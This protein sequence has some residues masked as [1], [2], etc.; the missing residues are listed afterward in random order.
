MVS[1]MATDPVH[2]RGALGGSPFAQCVVVGLTFFFGSCFGRVQIVVSRAFDRPPLSRQL[3]LPIRQRFQV[4][5]Y[6]V[7]I[8]FSAPSAASRL[9][10]LG[11]G[12]A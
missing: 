8:V 1:E 3:C 11:F 2:L 7:L 10:L 12:S 5:S 4:A 6:S 9:P